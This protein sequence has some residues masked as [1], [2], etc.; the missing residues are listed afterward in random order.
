MDPGSKV[1]R[2]HTV[3]S[4]FSIN[5]ITFKCVGWKPMWVGLTHTTHTNP[6][7]KLVGTH[8]HERGLGLGVGGV[9]VAQKNPWVTPADH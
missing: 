3:G 7:P 2:M 1:S 4:N 8:T 6:Q 5:Y 9:R